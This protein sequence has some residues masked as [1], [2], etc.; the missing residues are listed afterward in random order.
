MMDWGDHMTTAGWIF[1]VF[2]MLIIFA[3]FVVTIFWIVSQLGARGGER[4][5]SAISAREIL[6][7][8]LASGEITADQY[9]QLREKLDARSA[10]SSDHSDEQ[11]VTHADT[12]G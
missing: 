6:D 4:T 10:Q 2:G 3:L 5:S 1:S 12:P 7:R 11:P 8:R 9:D